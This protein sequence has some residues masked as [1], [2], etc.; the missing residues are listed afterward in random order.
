VKTKVKREGRE[1]EREKWM[2]WDFL[3]RRGGTDF[4]VQQNNSRL[5]FTLLKEIRNQRVV[6]SEFNIPTTTFYGSVE[7]FFHCRLLYV[8]QECGF[9]T[10]RHVDYSSLVRTSIKW[11]S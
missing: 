4:R 9:K 11:H 8:Q 2:W 6:T 1:R 7:Y 5:A 10:T 3:L